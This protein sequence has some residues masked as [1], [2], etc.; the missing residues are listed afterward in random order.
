M[1]SWSSSGTVRAAIR[2]GIHRLQFM[3][4]FSSGNFME[5]LLHELCWSTIDRFSFSNS[6]FLLTTHS[7]NP[8][9][10]QVLN[11]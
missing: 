3:K 5:A 6:M 1:P 2:L 8:W 10:W 9:A 4:S 11:F 7:H